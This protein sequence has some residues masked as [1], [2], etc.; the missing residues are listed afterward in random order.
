[1]TTYNF[2]PIFVHFPIAFLLLYSVIKLLPFYKWFPKVAWRDI[3]RI[4]LFLGVIGI[5][6]ALVTGET[7]EEI[8]RPNHQLVEAH[9]FFAGITTALFLILLSGEIASMIN[10]RNFVYRKG[11]QW[12]SPLLHVVEKIVQKPIV[13][14]LLAFLGLLAISLTG[15]LGGVITHG[16]LADPLAG[17]VLKLLGINL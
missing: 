13:A 10:A 15:L 12:I 14:G 7:A 5:F 8:V 2:H 4:L 17:I 11:L 16:P 1:M 9:S 6:G 3:E